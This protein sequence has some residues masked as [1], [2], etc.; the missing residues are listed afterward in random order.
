MGIPWI[1]LSQTYGFIGN[2]L[3]VPMERTSDAGLDPA[4]WRAVPTFGDASV[5]A[6]VAAL[7]EFA[8]GAQARRAR[9]V[10]V[11]EAVSVEF[12]RLFV[13]PP[14]PAAPPWETLHRSGA[15]SV[16]FGQATVEMRSLLR[17]A[18]LAVANENRQYEDH[19]G[20]ELLYLCEMCRR[21][22]EG[23]SPSNVRADAG[24]PGE[25]ELAKFVERHPLAWIGSLRAA[26]AA[27]SPEGY[28]NLLIA[29]AESVLAS[30]AKAHPATETAPP[31]SR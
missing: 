26:V 4:F 31:I 7:E 2:S 25:A 27:D 6:S 12:T 8:E 18:G 5:R 28:F 29:W 11:V 17:A 9:G 15:G 14:K 20:L 19:L 24:C 16:G 22:A 13:G 1:D 3:L 21:F 10:D 30:H 23:E